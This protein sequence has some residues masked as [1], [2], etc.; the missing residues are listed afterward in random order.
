MFQASSTSGGLVVRFNI[1]LRM[2]LKINGDKLK[3]AIGASV[4]AATRRRLTQGQDGDG[5]P[6]PAPES[7]TPP[8]QRT[9]V[10]IKSIKYW[11]RMGIVAP[12]TTAR[13]DVSARARSNFGLM[14]IHISGI[15][16]K[17]GDAVDRPALVDPMGQ[18]S[19]ETFK[20]I[21]KSGTKELARQL[22]KNEAGLLLELQRGGR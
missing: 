14:S 11:A 7:G 15:Y 9:G 3:R 8:L 1:P 6:L 20:A 17:D 4:A 13:P 19:P 21:E 12:S 16:S 2:R 18:N 22:K 5:R 10:M